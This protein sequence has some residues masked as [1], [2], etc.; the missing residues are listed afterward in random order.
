MTQ[1]F[2]VLLIEDNLTVQYAMVEGLTDAGHVV[3]VAGSLGRALDVLSHYHYYDVI[4]LDLRLGDD[5]GEDIFV[6]L[7]EMDIQVPPVVIISAQSESEIQRA[8]EIVRAAEVLR[9][10]ISI[11]QVCGAMRHAVSTA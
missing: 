8:A 9:K 11:E 1:A 7:R 5:R 2:N 4:L 3:S 10:P 6:R